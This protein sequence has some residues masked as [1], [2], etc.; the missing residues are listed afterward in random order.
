[1]VA[2]KRIEIITKWIKKNKQL[3]SKVTRHN[4]QNFS[5]RLRIGVQSVT[6]Y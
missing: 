1:M 2:E 5:V 3:Y 6:E 4:E